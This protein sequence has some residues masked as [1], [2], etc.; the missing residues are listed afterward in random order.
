VYLL[1][2]SSTH[3]DSLSDRWRSVYSL[4]FVVGPLARRQALLNCFRPHACL[5]GSSIGAVHNDIGI[6][7]FS[8]LYAPSPSWERAVLEGLPRT[9]LTLTLPATEHRA[10]W[11]RYMYWG[12][13]SVCENDGPVIYLD[14]MVAQ[15]QEQLRMLTE[16][17]RNLP[18]VWFV[19][20]IVTFYLS[21]T[22]AL[23]RLRSRYQIIIFNQ[24]IPFS[25]SISLRS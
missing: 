24:N 8:V 7:Q 10:L 4:G 22:L 3:L 23:Y 13:C 6:Y 19:G 9:Q 20:V 25:I 21:A 12:E 15:L 2:W 16:R 17:K 18:L 5:T 11:C 14:V 1:F